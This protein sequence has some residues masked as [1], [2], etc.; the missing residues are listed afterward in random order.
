MHPLAPDLTNLSN[1]ELFKKYNDLNQ[2]FLMARRSGSGA[3]AGQMSMLL[4]DYRQELHRRH[5]NMLNDA[6]KNN[7]NFKNIIDI[8]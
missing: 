1:D 2:K 5:Q 6:S 7:N 8:K 4:E 3:V